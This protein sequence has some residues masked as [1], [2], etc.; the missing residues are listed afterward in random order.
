MN[1]LIARRK[2]LLN[3]LPDHALLLLSSGQIIKA[4]QDNNYPFYLNRNFFYLAN[5]KQVN[6]FFLIDKDRA[7]SYL[8]I[9][10][11]DRHQ[12]VWFGRKLTKKEA[13]DASLVDEVFLTSSL[14][15]E[16]DRLM[17]HNRTLYLD[18]GA[19]SYQ[20]LS[21]QFRDYKIA[22][23]NPILTSMRLM[24]DEE[25]VA[26]I[27]KAIDITNI[28]LTKITSLLKEGKCNR[29]VEIYNAFNHAILD[30][31]THEIGFPSIIASGIHACCL[32]YPTPY[33]RLDKKGVLLCD[34]GSGYN[35]YSADVTRTY[36]ISG[37]F[38][39]QQALIYQ[40]V[41]DA[42]KE[43]IKLIKPGMTFKSLQT[44]TK[45]FLAARC[46]EKGLIKKPDDI[47]NYYMH[48]V[49]HPLGLDTHDVGGRDLTYAPG[50]VITVEPG[51]YFEKLKIGVR[52][53]DDVLVT[54]EGHR[55][56]SAQIPKEIKD[57]EA[58]FK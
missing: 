17:S 14:R 39:P 20:T 16:V 58:L 31:G 21:A 48:S 19:D 24:K 22:D 43:A 53:E 1:Y 28:G 57:I 15:E 33:D 42:N 41:L 27:K 2:K 56:L 45:E 32:H 26:C 40:I 52:I 46:L 8:F 5:I 25:E 34:V 51:L 11:Y 49:S 7:K 23:V 9:D 6:S 30:E 50:M 55:V 3:A 54:E 44:F 13:L 38:T 10:A 18:Y 36:P 47:T 37:K 12:E 29:E 35:C 4:S